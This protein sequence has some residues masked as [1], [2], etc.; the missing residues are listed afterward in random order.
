MRVLFRLL[1]EGVRMTDDAD[2][3]EPGSGVRHIDR[4]AVFSSGGIPGPALARRSRPEI[5]LNNT[6][7]GISASIAVA[8]LTVRQRPPCAV[9]MSNQ[10]SQK[11]NT[12]V[13]ID[14]GTA[15]CRCLWSAHAVVARQL[16]SMASKPVQASGQLATR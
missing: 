16:R 6:A 13:V 14:A 11:S 3:A 1:C 15:T 7:S 12:L 8:T 4:S 2:L 5:M 10:A 9:S